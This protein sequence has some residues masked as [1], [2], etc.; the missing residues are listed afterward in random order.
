MEKF[1][2]STQHII[3]ELLGLGECQACWPIVSQ[4]FAPPAERSLELWAPHTFTRGCVWSLHC[5]HQ[6]VREW[7]KGNEKWGLIWSGIKTSYIYVTNGVCREQLRIR[8]FIWLRG[9]GNWSVCSLH[10]AASHWVGLPGSSAGERGVAAQL[11][12][13]ASVAAQLSWRAS[14]AAQL[15]GIRLTC[16]CMCN[17]TILFSSHLLTVR[18]EVCA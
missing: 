5:L 8:V 16:L 10:W 18:T 9:E 3:D 2:S 1:A 11:S 12:R 7:G 15:S 13:R 6:W 17:Y 4:D 14:V